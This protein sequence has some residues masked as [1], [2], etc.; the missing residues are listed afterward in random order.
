ML[1]SLQ[2]EKPIAQV[3][4]SVLPQ[5]I[6]GVRAFPN[7]QVGAVE[8]EGAVG[9]VHL[10]PVDVVEVY[11]VDAGILGAAGV[12]AQLFVLVLVP[13]DEGQVGH[14]RLQPCGQL[15][16]VQLGRAV[17]VRLGFQDVHLEKKREKHLKGLSHVID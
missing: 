5:S 3:Y 7:I 9:C 10:L 11:V 4:R 15:G 16:F 8:E 2:Q 13:V 6:P 1:L 17:N 12:A 14:A